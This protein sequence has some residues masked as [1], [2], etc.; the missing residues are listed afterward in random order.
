MLI[1]KHLYFFSACNL[2]RSSIDTPDHL[3]ASVLEHEPASPYRYLEPPRLRPQLKVFVQ[4][5][6]GKAVL[7][8]GG[9]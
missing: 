7:E 6:L 3:S 9:H 5:S 2:V 8:R 1:H 4:Y